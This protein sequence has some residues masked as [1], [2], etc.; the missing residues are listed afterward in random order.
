MRLSVTTKIFLG[1]AIV[2]LTFGLVSI[3][4]VVQIHRIGQ[5]LELISHSYLPLT[6]T[7][8]E[9]ESAHKNRARDI[10]R[11]IEE[12]PAPGV[13]LLIIKLHRQFYPRTVQKIAGARERCRAGRD[14]AHSPEDAVFLDK[15]EGRLAR[16]EG[17]YGRYDGR[18]QSLSLR[19]SEQ[20][21]A[22]DPTS[23]GEVIV[24]L[25]ETDRALAAELKALGTDLERRIP[26]QV[27]RT[28]AQENRVAFAI[29]VLSLAAMLMALMVT[30]FVQRT[31]RPIRLLTHA[32]G[33]VS[34]GDFQGRVAAP[35][36]DEIGDLGRAF[37][38][39]AQA[40]EERDVELDAQRTALLRAERL[41]AVG[42]IA[43]QVSHEIRNPLSSIGLNAELLDE[44]I[45][46]AH[47]DA[48]HRKDEARN[49]L[50]AIAKEVDRLTEI[51]DE[52]L[53]FARMPRP[54]LA[55]EDVNEIVRGVV[56]F[57]AEEMNASH[58]E[59]TMELGRDL[60]PL[61]ADHSQLRRALLNL[62]RNAR[63]AM[64]DGGT[65]LVRTART[66]FGV[67]ISVC[68]DG[69]GIP[70]EDREH[71]FDVFFSTKERGTGLG[72]ALTAQIVA[73]HSGRISCESEV[74]RGTTFVIELTALAANEDAED[75]A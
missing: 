16:L 38:S 21:D 53:N 42:Q 14:L 23:L 67:E 68:D 46:S 73:E 25:R 35:G 2:V 17:L 70:E 45:L 32:L 28:E 9:L 44:E 62:L 69:P 18:L 39:M 20:S 24:E 65:L 3:Y 10:T 58:V 57:T 36:Q 1:L 26:E 29:M 33:G 47:F 13:Q 49:L 54:T 66:A 19:L 61:L 30:L 48:P 71:I 27:R 6:K 59:V 56:S 63:E 55:R 60:P 34:R 11:L 31:L 43:A 12:K 41:A 52:Y 51:T 40:L 4:A 64:L 22:V 7:A 74:G 75:A 5:D 37:N 15:I 72:L 50:S 8:A